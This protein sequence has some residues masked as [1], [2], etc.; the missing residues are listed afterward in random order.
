MSNYPVDPFGGKVAITALAVGG[1]ITVVGM[2]ICG[3]IT[4]AFLYNAPW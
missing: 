3:A 2:L 1:I 4:V